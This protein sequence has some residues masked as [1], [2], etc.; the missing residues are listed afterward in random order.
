[1][2]AEIPAAMATRMHELEARDADERRRG[3]PAAER[4]CQVPPETGRL[5]ALL[6]ATA[7]A[8][9]WLEVGTSAGYST[10]WL[11]LA[12]RAT[13]RRVRTLER[14]EWKLALARETF[15]RAGVEDVVELVAGDAR[16]ALAG[17]GPIGFCFLDAAKSEHTDYYA[18]AVP[19]LARGG[20]LVADNIVSHTEAMAPFM[21]SAHADPRLDAAVL[22]VGK[23]LLLGRRT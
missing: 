1:M 20:L 16:E 8:G 7:P 19:R 6:A 10:L 23:G 5:L 15:A 2:F 11:A 14:A 17:A 3:L 4:L 9:E 21:A 18:L 22:G 12:A 13:G